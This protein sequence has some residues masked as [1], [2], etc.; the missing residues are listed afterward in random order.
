MKCEYCEVI[1]GKKTRS[2]GIVFENKRVIV[3]LG[4]QHHKGHT[5]VVLKR[6]E[7]DM[8]NLTEEEKECFFTCMLKIA[9]AVKKAMNPDKLNYALFGNWVDHLHWHIYPR[10]KTDDDWGDPP[11][12]G[13]KIVY[14]ETEMSVMAKKIRDAIDPD[15]MCEYCKKEQGL[16]KGN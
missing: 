12:F 4:S 11:T 16:K 8:L 14:S 13:K 3:F 5:A 1:K 7:E 9:K 15:I 2:G 6:H 10:Y